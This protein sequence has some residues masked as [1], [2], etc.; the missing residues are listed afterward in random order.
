MRL[1]EPLSLGLISQ[2][3]SQ[4]G[5]PD[6]GFSAFSKEMSDLIHIFK[7]FLSDALELA[8]NAESRTQV[9]IPR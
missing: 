8:N 2:T 5:V 3:D 4:G 6:Q 9:V 7:S 1:C